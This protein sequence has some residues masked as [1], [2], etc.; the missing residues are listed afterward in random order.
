MNEDQKQI[1]TYDPLNVTLAVSGR[2]VTGFAEEGV[3]TVV[4]NEDRVTPT[5]GVK[6]DVTYNKNANN[7]ANLAITLKSTSASLAYLRG[8]ASRAQEVRID[9][10]DANEDDHLHISEERCM[11]LK[12]PDVP[13]GAEQATVTVN[14]FIPDCNIR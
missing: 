7:S 5:V 13:R 11:I 14:I 1:M 4:Y 8:L 10:S 3:L 6:G 12:V 9:I 2:A